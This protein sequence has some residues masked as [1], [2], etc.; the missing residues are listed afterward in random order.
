[1]HHR[2]RAL[3]FSIPP[4]FTDPIACGACPP[5]RGSRLVIC[6]AWAGTALRRD[7]ANTHHLTVMN[8][9]RSFA[10]IVLTTLALACSADSPVEPIDITT[11]PVIPTPGAIPNLPVLGHGN[12]TERYSAEVWVRG[13]YAYT[14][15][16]GTRGA[17]VG[18]RLKVWNVA[19]ANPVL[20]H[21]ATVTG[22]TTLGDVQV[23]DDG[24]ILV[25]PTE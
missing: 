3:R 22:A 23:S 15:T 18:N 6:A 12:V 17:N 2:C 1:M 19:G 24:S 13:D 21:E 16:W 5:E 14:T 9:S 8:R 7:Q 10:S 20:I 25:V 4:C 11:P